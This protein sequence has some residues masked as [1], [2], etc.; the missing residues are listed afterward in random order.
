MPF[1]ID[2]CLGTGCG[3]LGPGAAADSPPKGFIVILGPC[4]VAGAG[5]GTSA[6]GLDEAG[7]V[8]GTSAVGLDG[9]VGVG[10]VI[11]WGRAAGL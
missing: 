2:T 7:A 9:A 1:R 4:L 3:L 5:A 8:A 11:P 10:V 6:T